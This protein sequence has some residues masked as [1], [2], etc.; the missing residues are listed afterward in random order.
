MA[1]D[2]VLAAE[3]KDRP[4]R[5]FPQPAGVVVKRIDPRTGL[6]APAG[7]AGIDEYFLDGTEPKEVASPDG[8]GGDQYFINGG[9]GAEPTPP[10][11][12]P[13]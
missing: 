8:A 7:G 2:L 10:P 1:E 5:P 13:R 6:F 11:A 12:P 4:V 9:A 3:E